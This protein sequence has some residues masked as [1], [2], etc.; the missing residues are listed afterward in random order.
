[1]KQQKAFARSIS[2]ELALFEW[3][4]VSNCDT[5]L[6]WIMKMRT[7]VSFL[8]AVITRGCLAQSL[9]PSGGTWINTVDLPVARYNHSAILLEDGR[10]LIAGGSPAQNPE[11]ADCQL[12]DPAIAT[13]TGTGSLKIARATNLAVRLN[14][15][16]VLIAGGN[17]ISSSTTAELYDPTTGIWSVT[18]NMTHDHLGGAITL[19]QDGRALVTGGAFGEIYNPT[20]GTW[21]RTAAANI[22]RL[23]HTA[24]LLPDGKVLVAGGYHL[25]H[26]IASSAEL[27]DPAAN[28]WTY[29]GS[30][31]RNRSAHV[32]ALLPDS[33]VL[34]AGGVA[35]LDSRHYLNKCELYDPSTGTWELT[36]K[37]PTARQQ[38]QTSVLPD[39]RVVVSGGLT[40]VYNLQVA[41][42]VD[43]Y[44]PVRRK[45]GSGGSVNQA[46]WLHTSTL[47]SNGQILITGGSDYSTAL[48]SSELGAISSP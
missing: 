18:G 28:T 17:S 48:S 21:S 20:T 9:L 2:S 30:L 19:L 25:N 39:G 32:A 45:W 44:D 47:L 31:S 35:D 34:V 6:W 22:A 16:R 41:G 14:D 37:I 38:A 7:F 12:Y 13:W 3:R 40:G 15:E 4:A 33:T 36:A 10:V 5:N 8:F 43:V 1:M 46:R 24:T 23:Y 42:T 27:Y 29:T 26:G 11:T